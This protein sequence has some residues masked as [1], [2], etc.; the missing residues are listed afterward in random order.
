MEALSDSEGCA[1]CTEGELVEGPTPLGAVCETCGAVA[2]A[3]DHSVSDTLTERS[4]SHNPSWSDF[5]RIT[6][7][8]EGQVAAAL[9]SLER[10]GEKLE[11]PPE[12]RRR[13]GEL[14][15]EA[16]IGR[17]T[18]G[19]STEL[20]VGAALILA[21][22]ELK[23]P[24]PTGRVAETANLSIKGLRRALGVF[25]RDLGH[26]IPGCLP[27]MYVDEFAQLLTLDKGIAIGAQQLLDAL[28][29]GRMGGKHPGAVAGAALYLAADGELTQ[30]EVARVAGV[31]TETIRLRVKECRAEWPLSS[32][33]V[34]VTN[35]QDD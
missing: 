32:G 22:W 10:L 31:T 21:G 13:A 25:R 30:R 6:N 15:A 5:V 2:S 8:T 12:V 27:G 24:N 19:R 28:P 11:T 3:V 18:D 29:A 35:N 7:S 1:I 33:S 14:Y 23:R 9:E 34:G 16:A 4:R 26:L 20:M 17:H